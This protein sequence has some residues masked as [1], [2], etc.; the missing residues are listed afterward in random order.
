MKNILI[1][2]QIDFLKAGNQTL[3]NTVEGYIDNG[4]F[5]HLLTSN[6]ADNPD[7]YQ[8]GELPS[9]IQKGLKIYRFQTASAKIKAL[10]RKNS[11]VQSNQIII[12]RKANDTVGFAPSGINFQQYIT[13]LSFVIGG[14]RKAREIMRHNR[15]D[16]FYGYELYGAILASLL[17]KTN[18]TRFVTRFQGTYLFPYLNDKFLR[19]KMPAQYHSIRIKSD[20]IIMTNDGTHGDVACK[21]LNPRT[22]FIFLINGLSDAIYLDKNVDREAILEKLHIP[23]RRLIVLASSRLVDWKRLDRVV[24]IAFSLKNDFNNNDFSFIVAGDGIEFEAIK[25]K[26]SQM[27]LDNYVFLLGSVKREEL[28]QLYNISDLVASFFDLS[29]FS[30][31]IIEATACGR[32]VIS[33][34]DNSSNELLKNGYNSILIKKDD[35]LIKNAANAINDIATS[36][37]LMIKLQKNAYVMSEQILSWPERMKKEIEVIESLELGTK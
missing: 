16:L 34:D 33:I 24:D 4:Y 5:V 9:K 14:Y 11:K 15:I 28:N 35:D 18:R 7:Y 31:T 23:S 27:N 36:D 26:V 8:Y 29:N 13:I 2:I 6:P 30:N 19:L 22:K 10:R 20:L 17:R 32:P 37:D 25:R 12:N 1:I 3:L 21:R